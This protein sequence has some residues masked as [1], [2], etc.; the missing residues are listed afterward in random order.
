LEV[1]S[2]YTPVYD[3]LLGWLTLTVGILGY[4]FGQLGQYMRLWPVENGILIGMGILAIVASRSRTRYAVVAALVLG[5]VLFAWGV[6]GSVWPG[7]PA[8]SAEPLESA[9]RIVAGAWG[10]YLSVEDTLTWRRQHRS[11]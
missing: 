1:C 8:L 7:I 9:C 3:R 2:V 11:G 4:L 5:L 10:V 6:V